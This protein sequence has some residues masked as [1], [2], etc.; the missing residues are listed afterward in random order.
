MLKKEFFKNFIKNNFTKKDIVF[1]LFLFIFC[2]TFLYCF[3]IAKIEGSSM[4]PNFYNGERHF[5]ISEN[6]DLKTIEYKDVV[7]VNTKDTNLGV[8]HIIKRV[9]GTPGDTIEIKDNVLYLN[10]EALTEPYIKEQMITDDIQKITLGENEYFVCG[11]NRNNS[12]DSRVL[13]V[14]NSKYIEYRILK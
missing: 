12:L 10:G 2:F 13:G 14:I 6:V 5:A 1:Y 8:A 9:I 7:I 11:D 4:V 3:K